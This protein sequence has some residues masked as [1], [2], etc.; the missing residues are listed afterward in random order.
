MGLKVNSINW[1]MFVFGV[2][3]VVM[4]LFSF[5]SRRVQKWGM[6]YTPQG[7]IWEKLVG[8]KWA[9]FVVKY[10]FSFGFFIMA[11]FAFFDS[12]YGH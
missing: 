8:D 5:F 7:V 3:C 9:R 11:G 10:L 1:G 6:E 2:F 4:A 12:I